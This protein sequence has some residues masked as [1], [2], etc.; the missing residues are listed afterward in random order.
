MKD[1]IEGFWAKDLN[2]RG[3]LR[4]THHRG[5]LDYK[6]VIDKNGFS[7]ELINP[8]TEEIEIQDYEEILFDCLYLETQYNKKEVRK[9]IGDMLYFNDE[10]GLVE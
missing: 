10:G 6:A 3:K 1:N 7:V 5:N 8:E 4:R 2:I 9:I